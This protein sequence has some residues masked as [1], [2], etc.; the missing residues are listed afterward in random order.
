MTRHAPGTPVHLFPN[1]P[2]TVVAWSDT[3]GKYLV[4][5]ETGTD[6]WVGPRAVRAA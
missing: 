1:V 3:D 4:Q 6:H 5:D 2:A